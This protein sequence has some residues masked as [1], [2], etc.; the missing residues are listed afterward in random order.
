MVRRR[1]I[2]SMT[3]AGLAAPAAVRTAQ[4][5]EHR[6]V[7]YRIEGFTC[8]ACAVGLETMLRQQKGIVRATASYPKAN[9]QIE[10]NPAE[11]SDKSIRGY[12]AEM[13]FRV[14]EENGR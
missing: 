6:T 8:I 11:I 13:G 7:T 1:F 2:Q 4:A 12:I 10:F 3:W 5:T 9:V 14:A